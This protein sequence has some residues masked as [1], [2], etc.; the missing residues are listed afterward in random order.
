MAAVLVIAVVGSAIVVG[1][2]RDR[3]IAQQTEEIGSLREVAAWTIRID[4]QAD[5]RHVALAGVGGTPTGTL[6]FS[7]T[8]T[9]VV[10]VAKGL[11]EPAAGMEYRCWVEVD[12]DRRRVGWMLPLGAGL[13]YWVGK[14]S[15]LS[16]VDPG[17]TFGVSLAPVSGDSVVGDP[18]IVGRS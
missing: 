3:E 11:T 13:T 16:G 2:G 1:S 5:A 17:T 8:S 4:R 14:A 9:D 18:V 7:P 15:A 12:G 6:I 10:V